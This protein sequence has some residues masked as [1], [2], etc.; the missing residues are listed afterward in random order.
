MLTN[1]LFCVL[2]V[3]T[4][5]HTDLPNCVIILLLPVG[6]S[7]YDSK[8]ILRAFIKGGIQ[9]HEHYTTSICNHN[10]ESTRSKNTLFH[11]KCKLSPPFML[12]AWQNAN[13]SLTPVLKYANSLVSFN[14][15]FDAYS[16]AIIIK[17][18]R[19][20]SESLVFSKAN[21]LVVKLQLATLMVIWLTKVY[22]SYQYARHF[23]L[24]MSL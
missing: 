21:M 14:C 4:P 19:N 15:V 6:K 1:L 2:Q 13:L 17:S 9:S 12:K 16:A 24:W 11:N 3:C 20:K 22:L 8:N 10:L 5:Q 23:I 18:T 7:P